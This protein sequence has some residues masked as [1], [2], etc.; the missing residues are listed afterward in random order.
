MKEKLYHPLFIFFFS[1]LLIGSRIVIANSI[2]TTVVDSLIEQALKLRS[3]KPDSAIELANEALSLI[4]TNNWKDREAPAL[5]A[6]G[7]AEMY[8]G[9]LLRALKIQ[10][11]TLRAYRIQGDSLGVAVAMINIGNVYKRQGDYVS[12]LKYQLQ[13]LKLREK[14]GAS[15]AAIAVCYNNIGNLYRVLDDYKAAI[16]YHRRALAIREEVQDSSGIGASY[17]NMGLL[18]MLAE[19][20]DTADYYYRK[21][22]EIQLAKKDK[23][24]IAT[25]YAGLAGLHQNM[26]NFEQAEIYYLQALEINE[27]TGNKIKIT[28]TLSNMA[29]MY[30]E[31]E[32]PDQA[33]PLLSRALDLAQQAGS[34]IFV[35]YLNRDLA[36]AYEQK[37]DFKS[38]YQNHLVFSTLRDSFLGEE[39]RKNLAQLKVAYEDEQKVETIAGLEQ[40]NQL[41][42]RERNLI[43]I[44]AALLLVALFYIFWMNRMRQKNLQQLRTE[45][46]HS[47]KLLAEKEQLLTDLQEA[48]SQIIQ[49]EKMASLGQ[50]TAGIAHEINNPINFITSNVHALKLDFRD[51][52]QLLERVSQLNPCKD[53]RKCIEEIETISREIEVDYLRTEIGNLIKGIERGANRTQNIVAS[54]RTF[55]RDT[56]EAFVDADIHEGI[57]STLTILNNKLLHRIQVHKNYGDLPSIKCQISKLNQVF[58]NILNNGIQAIEG[59]G[60]IYI[61]TFRENGQIHISFKDTGK[62]IDQNTKNR[63]FEPF[64][65]TKR[66]GEGT[67]LGLAISY[68]IIEEHQGQISVNSK[69]GEGTEFVVSLPV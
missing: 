42:T 27:S 40:S 19:S 63:I 8:S 60:E 55:S 52:E 66:I 45:K 12:S 53:P 20:Y 58:L 64:F 59:E 46:E 26:K 2:D 17:S 24:E 4:E 15:P 18:Y 39:Y 1:F 32:Q 22:L 21:A 44:G 36:K 29:R 48:Q 7:L 65:T 68:G 43:L 50:L 34:T 5:R 23:K 38:A 33:L 67:G 41:R 31:Q 16:D 11:K 54:L 25:C 14:Y 10:T 9:N 6:L 49:S 57:D 61:K 69:P 62:G 3:G 56:K 28:R 13:A 35:Q 47:E 30:L 37:G 51:I